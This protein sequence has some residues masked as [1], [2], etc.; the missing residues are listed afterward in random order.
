VNVWN[1]V[2]W[3]SLLIC[4]EVSMCVGDWVG[5]CM[6]AKGRRESMVGVLVGGVFEWSSRYLTTCTVLESTVHDSR[7]PM[8]RHTSKLMLS[9]QCSRTNWEPD[10]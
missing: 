10:W 5:S 3:S 8:D 1:C 4:E 2:S 6:Y 9:V 7:V